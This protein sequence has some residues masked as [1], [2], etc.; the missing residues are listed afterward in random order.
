MDTTL[1]TNKTSRR[2]TPYQDKHKKLVWVVYMVLRGGGMNAIG[3]FDSESRAYESIGRKTASERGL[4]AD[5]SIIVEAFELNQ[6]KV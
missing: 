1:D 3:L 4:P 5:A 2:I 6:L